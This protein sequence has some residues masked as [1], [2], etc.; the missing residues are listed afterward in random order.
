MI[1]RK[2]LTNPYFVQNKKEKRSIYEE[3]SSNEEPGVEH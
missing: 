3:S 1:L 2:R